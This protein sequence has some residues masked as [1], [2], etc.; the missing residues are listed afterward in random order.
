MSMVSLGG[1][2]FK[3]A[4][5]E[6][7]KSVVD[8][9]QLYKVVHFAADWSK[10]LD[11]DKDDPD[12]V[13]FYFDVASGPNEGVFAELT[14]KYPVEN[15][16]MIK[17]LKKSFKLTSEKA[18]ALLKRYVVHIANESMNEKVGPAILQIVNTTGQIDSDLVIGT[19]TGIDTVWA[20]D[21]KGYYNLD[22]NGYFPLVHSEDVPEKPTGSKK[23]KTESAPKT[24][25]TGVGEAN[26][27]GQAWT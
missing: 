2:N 12:M 18:L 22:V 4:E 21:D 8:G 17:Y 9:V 14:E 7:F 10:S 25:G 27:P 5:E 15:Y 20:L 3:N 13:T 16:P 19:V 24:G 23:P 1:E 26:H 6:E 11:P